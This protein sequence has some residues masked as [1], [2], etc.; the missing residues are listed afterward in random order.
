MP[1]EERGVRVLKKNTILERIEAIFVKPK[2]PRMEVHHHPDLHH[3]KKKFGEY[4]LE[5]IMIFLAV[6]MGFFA[7]SLREHI[8]EHTRVKEYARSLVHDIAQDT[9]MVNETI[10]YINNSARHI[11]KFVAF[12]QGKELKQLRN[13]DIYALTIFR[14]GYRPYTWNRATLEQIKNSG[15]LRYFTN[16]SILNRISAYDAFTRHLD[17]DYKDDE[18]RTNQSA[19]MRGLIININYPDKLTAMLRSGQDSL[20]STAYY[21]EI[22]NSGPALLTRDINEIIRLANKKI[23]I[24]SA[25]KVRS[26]EELPRLIQDG[27]KL[28][29]LLKSEYDLQ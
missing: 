3:K 20:L 22:A 9:L 10:G 17:E 24:R 6:T 7:E 15:S 29:S 28:I 25:L 19:D 27:A 23:V 13:I 4:I 18:D 11:D 1:N 16:D 8:S 26:D 21:N 14:D 2:T 5:F 12:T